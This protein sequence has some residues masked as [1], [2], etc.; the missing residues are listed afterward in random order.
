VAI[1]SSAI[2]SRS[3]PA[4]SAFLDLLDRSVRDAA[5]RVVCKD[6]E[7]I[8]GDIASGL[9]SPAPVLTLV[10]HDNRFFGRALG[11]GSLG[12]GE[13]WM[14][15]D[16]DVP[17]PGLPDLITLFLKSHLDR[18]VRGDWRL[19]ARVLWISLQNR[20]LGR[21]RNVER[22]FDVGDDLIESFLDPTLTYTCGF[23][24]SRSDDLASLQQQKLARICSK[25]RL[26][27]GD[28]LLDIGCG[29]AGLLIYAVQQFKVTGTGIVNSP[30]H[31]RKAKE[32]VEKAGL[33][34]QIEIRFEDHRSVSGEFDKVVSVGMH[35]HLPRSEHPRYFENVAKVLAPG[36]LV[37]AHF[38]GCG[39]AVNQ[40][41][42]FIQKY[43]FPG[44]CQ[45]K[46]SEVSN[47]LER[48][49]LAILHVE[50][51]V[52]HYGL[53]CERWL[54]NFQQARPSLDSSRYDL[55]FQRMFEYYLSICIGAARA[56]DGAVYQVLYGKDFDAEHPLVWI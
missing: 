49:E 27:E 48:N 15:G 19:A 38:I 17:D 51:I 44:S 41:D 28:R 6:G 32:Q 10:V 30:S 34:D 55:K 18:A 40:H 2:G 47:L 33:A 13:A 11:Q 12:M 43:I 56:S 26:R 3:V 36:G 7:W 46:L 9:H 53:T 16:F 14:D 37:L 39:V 24:H 8:V 21:R 20:I 29:Y 42:P 54:E 23:A 45:L 22:H 5:V 4:R 1:T 52:R 25:L 31:Y 35:E 50:N